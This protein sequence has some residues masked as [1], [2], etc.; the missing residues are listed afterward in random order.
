MKR[1]SPAALLAA[2]CRPSWPCRSWRRTGP[3]R[4]WGGGV[5][6][7]LVAARDAALEYLVDQP[8]G[9]GLA[10]LVQLDARVRLVGAQ[11]DDDGHVGRAVAVGVLQHVGVK[12]LNACPCCGH[13][14]NS[15]PQNG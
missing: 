14:Q 5:A 4:A 12:P 8:A 3:V 11:P 13:P 2:S 15:M 9:D 10:F 1:T 7:D 6:F